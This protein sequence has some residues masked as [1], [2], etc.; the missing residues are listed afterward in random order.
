[1]TFLLVRSHFK[2]LFSSTMVA[3]FASWSNG[4][5]DGKFEKIANN[6]G[7]CY[8]QQMTDSLFSLSNATELPSTVD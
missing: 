6:H 7:E 2:C 3:V 1:M 4:E 8:S 5:K